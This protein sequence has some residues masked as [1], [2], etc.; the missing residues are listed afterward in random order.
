MRDAWRTSMGLQEKMDRCVAYLKNNLSSSCLNGAF[1]ILPS[2][3]TP[4]KSR[5][6]GTLFH[7]MQSEEND[8]VNPL[9]A[10][11]S[12]FWGKKQMNKQMML[13]FTYRCL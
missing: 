11:G 2:G 10:L 3:P 8:R 6:H 7:S 9:L 4:P 5:V 1:V 12:W 13:E